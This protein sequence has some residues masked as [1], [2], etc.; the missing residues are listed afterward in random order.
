VQEFKMSTRHHLPPLMV[1]IVF[2]FMTWVVP[3]QGWGT[4]TDESETSADPIG[5]R[6]DVSKKTHQARIDSIKREV[7]TSLDQKVVAARKKKGNKTLVD[8]LATERGNF[9]NDLNNLPQSLG[10]NGAS[11]ARRIKAAHGE[12]DKVYGQAMRDYTSKGQ[13][14]QA[15]AVRTERE[16]FRL[17]NAANI[18]YG[19]EPDGL[20]QPPVA[21]VPAQPAL[22]VDPNI[23]VASSWSFTRRF[24]PLNQSGAFKIVDGVIYHLDA[25]H[26]VGAATLDAQSQIHL[27]FQNHRK[28]PAGEAIVWRVAKGEWRGFLVLNGDEW[29]LEMSRR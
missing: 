28:I 23:V 26:P 12:L 21:L 7:I 1:V 27:I 13:D 3:C 15:N 9:E 10:K 29:K 2:L 5:A 14:E 6:L 16:K 17:K 20:D 8:R 18:P 4:Q 11:F 24:G 25:D 22:G 19:R